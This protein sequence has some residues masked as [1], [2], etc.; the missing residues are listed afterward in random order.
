MLPKAA[1]CPVCDA[2]L[3]YATKGEV[4][5]FVCKECQWIFTWN[6]K[7]K[8]LPPV[9]ANMKM[10][11]TCDCGSCQYRDERKYLKGG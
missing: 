2:Q 8:L 3:G 10:P 1:N 6:A 11:E 4:C 9:R 5:M 7:G